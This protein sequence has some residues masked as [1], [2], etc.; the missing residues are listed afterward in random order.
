MDIG[1]IVLHLDALEYLVEDVYGHRK[2][3]P[4]SFAATARVSRF[5]GND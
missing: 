3:D 1:M 4:E 5:H 2:G